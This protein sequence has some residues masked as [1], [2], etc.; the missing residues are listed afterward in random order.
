M[1]PAAAAGA[2]PRVDARGDSATWTLDLA[3]GDVGWT[4]T[5][6]PK[7]FHYAF[8]AVTYEHWTLDSL[9]DRKQS[10]LF[11]IYMRGDR[12]PVRKVSVKSRAGELHVVVTNRRGYRIGSGVVYAHDQ[13]INAYVAPKFLQLPKGEARW[14]LSLIDVRK[15]QS[16][17]LP[18]ST[19]RIPD[20]S[21]YALG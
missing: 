16:F 5:R 1:P 10:F 19:D 12:W 4:R 9:H 7:P 17:S 2:S 13:T 21:R 14:T 11:Q 3:Y 6:Y 8:D 18:V 20:R 15:L